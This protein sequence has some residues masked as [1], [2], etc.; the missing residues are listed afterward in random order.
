[1][2]VTPHNP[3]W[4]PHSETSDHSPPAAP[5]GISQATTRPS[6][7]PDAKASTE[8]PETNNIKTR[9]KQETILTQK[10][11]QYAR[12][13]VH[14][15]VHNQPTHTHPQPPKPGTPD[16]SGNQGAL[17]Q[18]PDSSHPNTQD[19][20]HHPTGSRRRTC[21]LL[22]QQFR[23]PTQPENKPTRHASTSAPQ[24]ETPSRSQTHSK[25]NNV[26]YQEGRPK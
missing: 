8:R 4:S 14:Y 6:S 26:R 24:G 1:M 3:I 15:T 11:W 16:G 9:T 12:C 5:R 19:T 23:Q 18:D 25:P 21:N 7:A 22:C 2:Q 13:R 17:P 20:H 10:H